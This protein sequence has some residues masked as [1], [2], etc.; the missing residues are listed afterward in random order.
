MDEL[1]K[2]NN[3]SEYL[4]ENACYMVSSDLPEYLA[5]ILAK[6]RLTKSAV[7]KKTE[8][9]EITG[10]QIFSGVR[11][12]SRDS[13]LCVCRA[14]ELDISETQS[15]LKIGGFAELYPKNKRDAIIINGINLGLSVAGIN[16]IL[17][18][19]GENTLNK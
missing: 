12:P 19:N 1:M 3:I 11:N 14:L 18:D 8:L 15:L 13:L 9:S 16:E 6:K 17:Y 10:Y 2:S 5:N 7:I 4:K